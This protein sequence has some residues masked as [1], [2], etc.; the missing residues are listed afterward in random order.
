MLITLNQLKTSL[1]AF[2]DWVL[3]RIPSKTSDLTNDS[4]FV[5]TANIPTKVSDLVDDSG[6]YTKPSGGIPASDLASGVIPT[7]PVQDVTVNGISVVENGVAEIVQTDKSVWNMFVGTLNPDVSSADKYPHVDGQAVA[8]MFR[9]CTPSVAEHGFRATATG[10]MRVDFGNENKSNLN[11]FEVGEIYTLSCDLSAN[12]IRPSSLDEVVANIEIQLLTYNGYYGIADG[13]VSRNIEDSEYGTDADLGQVTF[14]FTVPERKDG[15]A[16]TGAMIRIVPIINGTYVYTEAG[17]Y[18]ELRN[19]MLNKGNGAS[20]WS[21]SLSEVM[22]EPPVQDV[23][24]NGTSIVD[25]GV[26]NI[27]VPEIDT[28]LTVAGKAADAKKVGDEITNVNYQISDVTTG[29]DSKAPV[30]LET[31]SG[32]IASFDDGA[33]SMPINKLVANIEPVQDLHGYDSPWPAGGGKN[34]YYFPDIPETTQR[35]VTY[36]VKDGILNINGTVTAEFMLNGVSLSLPSNTYTAS[37]Q[38]ISGSISGS[39][40]SFNFYTTTSERRWLVPFGSNGTTV[41][42]T[43][44]GDVARTN[45]T[46]NYNAVF[47][48]A[49]IA[50][51]FEEGSSMTNFSPYSNICPITGWR[52]AE[53]SHSGADTSSPETYNITFPAEAGTVYGGSLDVTT[54]VLTVDRAMVDLGTLTW[55]YLASNKIFSTS[56]N[57]KKP[58]IYEGAVSQYANGGWWS[59]WPN[60]DCVWC[61]NAANGGFVVKD[62]RFADTATFKSAMLGVQFC[63]KLA[64]PITYQLTPTEVRT[65]LGINNIWADTGDTEVT[66]RADTKLY[67]DNKITQAIAAALNV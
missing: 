62:T 24:I 7:V 61:G 14:T 5:T 56:I 31:V 10:M 50:F 67:I 66:Y 49:K 46:L 16:T 4:D 57:D 32:A 11:G 13:Y 26:A 40:S 48:N 37:A 2:K 38:L 58:S 35:G 52:G 1:S 65:L 34:K 39:N 8:T 64:I 19:L 17:S 60:K 20:S 25:S 22:S 15:F 55:A 47:D 53:I 27:H 6:H 18:V 21:P 9:S 33:D 45:I 51:Q 23:Q 29:L 28:T 30:I 44:T 59:G 43:A 12:I 36:S 42:V 54:G 3:A 41:S 63:Y